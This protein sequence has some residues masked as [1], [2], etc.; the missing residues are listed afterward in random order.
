MS[1]TRGLHQLSL[2]ELLSE[3]DLMLNYE[4]SNHHDPRFADRDNGNQAKRVTSALKY[5]IKSLLSSEI[6]PVRSRFELIALKAEIERRN[7]SEAE[8]N[9]ASRVKE[10]IQKLRSKRANKELSFFMKIFIFIIPEIVF[11]RKNDNGPSLGTREDED[12]FLQ[13]A[14]YQKLIKQRSRLAI[15]GMGFRFFLI[16]LFF[17]WGASKK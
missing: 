17:L 4:S 8:L 1:V 12:S 15:I 10:E 11:S 6:R 2:V 7:P 14:G 3:R 9:E 16:A 5:L 13:Q